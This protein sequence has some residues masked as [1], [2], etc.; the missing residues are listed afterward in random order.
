ME[1]LIAQLQKSVDNSLEDL[2]ADGADHALEKAETAIVILQQ[3][4]DELRRPLAGYQFAD[5]QQEITFFKSVLPRF[6]SG[7][8]YYA[9]L[10]GIERRMPEGTKETLQTYYREHLDR[11]TAWFQEYREY[12]E[13]YR[14]G[15]SYLDEQYFMRGRENYTFTRLAFSFA[16]DPQFCTPVSY[17]FATIEAHSRLRDYLNGQLDRLS[18]QSAPPTA[19]RDFDIQWT[20]SRA[21]LEEMTYAW[22]F[23]GSF[24]H[25]KVEIKKLYE[26]LCSFFGITPGNIYKSK[27]D[28]YGRSSMS[29]YLDVL[30]RRYKE[31]MEDTDERFSKR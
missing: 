22:Y 28:F 26:A 9:T 24:N 3:A 12:Y 5:P 15:A 29:A 6:Q 21:A 8:I 16:L 27:Q 2:F 31:G 30:S 4:L 17:L 23:K 19:A 1:T 10:A 14:S 13:Y 25:G 20:D 18:G 11:I 7:L